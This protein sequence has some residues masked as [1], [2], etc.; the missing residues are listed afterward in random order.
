MWKLFRM[1]GAYCPA[2]GRSSIHAEDIADLDP[3]NVAGRADLNEIYQWAEQL[4]IRQATEAI[5][6]LRGD[7]E[8]LNRLV[9]NDT[10]PSSGRR[11][12]G[13]EW[14]RH[15]RC[16]AKW[17]VLREEKDRSRLKF[18][19][20]YFAV[21]K[22][23]TTMRSIFDGRPLCELCQSP[24][25]VNIPDIPEILTRVQELAEQGRLETYTADIRHWF[26]QI[27]IK[28]GL[29]QFFGVECD[30]ARYRYLVLPMG[31]SFSP[32]ICQ[33]LAWTIIMKAVSE[34]V[35]LQLE[36][37]WSADSLPRFLKIRERSSGKVVAYIFLYYD[38]IGIFSISSPALTTLISRLEAAFGRANIAMK[39]H[40]RRSNAQLQTVDTAGQSC[41]YLGLEM[42]CSRL[43]SKRFTL[44]WRHVPQKIEES[45]E[46][47]SHMDVMSPRFFAHVVGK[48]V[49]NYIAR[50]QP[51]CYISDVLAG[52]GAAAKEARSSGWDRWTMK[53][54]ASMYNRLREEWRLFKDNPW[55]HG[56]PL[57]QQLHLVAV[58]ASSV[59]WGYVTLNME[60]MHI[61]I[62]EV[63]ALCSAVERMLD[64]GRRGRFLV[65]EDNSAARHDVNRMF[66]INV[67]A[68][69]AVR[70]LADRLRETA[71][72]VQ[73]MGITSDDN[74]A[75]SPSR[76]EPLDPWRVGMRWSLT[77]FQRN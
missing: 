46:L 8:V 29:G 59:G 42:A 38:N 66:T 47:P 26:H 21:P 72:A 69:R 65:A 74:A 60:E 77:F 7:Q 37:E 15:L 52:L 16:L 48:V 55:S 6:I 32:W 57:P 44:R 17:G 45:I 58:D 51:L 14:G 53:V 64:E 61:F 9:F 73:I 67:R 4:G 11:T 40:Q 49:W 75:D 12:T 63:V 27:P 71:S 25:P 68:N 43:G 41:H 76:L 1:Y 2:Y 5:D 62:L 34:C 39:E 50:R 18:L 24:P 70:R 10:P 13:A 22:T 3:I 19:C 28:E 30:G 20:R 33:V 54:E 31:W 36:G 23:P 35:F 56:S